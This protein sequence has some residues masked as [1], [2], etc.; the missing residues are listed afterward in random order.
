MGNCA[1]ICATEYKVGREEQ[2][3]FSLESYRRAREAAERANAHHARHCPN[4]RSVSPAIEIVTA[5]GRVRRGL[6]TSPPRV[7]TRA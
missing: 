5:I 2:D 6:R 1:E 4:A 3:A 7:A